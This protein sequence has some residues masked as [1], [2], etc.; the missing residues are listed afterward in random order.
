MQPK[1]FLTDEEMNTL[2]GGTQAPQGTTT[3]EP[4]A[5]PAFIP[6][7]RADEFFTANI[8]TPTP[9]KEQPGKL[10]QIATGIAKGELDLVQGASNVGKT[11]LSPVTKATTG[12]ANII[13]GRKNQSF[14]EGKDILPTQV[15]S[16]LE[17]ETPYESFGKGI[18][19]VVEYSLGGLEKL[20]L[21]AAKA[22]AKGL[23][24]VLLGPTAKKVLSKGA[25][26]LTDF[27]AGFGQSKL[28]GGDN[29]EATISGT[30]VPVGNTVMKGAVKLLGKAA[31]GVTDFV[32][33][34]VATK[35]PEFYDS[36]IVKSVGDAWNSA[37]P[38]SLSTM[39]GAGNKGE[40]ALE[41]LHG[42]ASQVVAN[43]VENKNSLGLVDKLG[44]PR[45]PEN[46]QEMDEAVGTLKKK[47]YQAYTDILKK[48]NP[49]EFIQGVQTDVSNVVNSLNNKL[50]KENSE[51]GR[52]ALTMLIR[53][54]RGLRDTSPIGLQDY[55]ERLRA[56]SGSVFNG[57]S[58]AAVAN[59]SAAVGSQIRD[60]IAKNIENLDGDEYKQLRGLY[61]AFK[62]IESDTE[63]AARNYINNV[64]DKLF[65]SASNIIGG[66]DTL[67]GLVT[68]DPM[69]IMRGL[70][71]KGAQKANAY[72]KS[73]ERNIKKMFSEVENIYNVAKKNTEYGSPSLRINKPKPFDG[74]Q[75]ANSATTNQNTPYS[76]SNPTPPKTIPAA[77]SNTID[78]SVPLNPNGVNGAVPPRQSIRDFLMKKP[79]PEA[80]G[81]QQMKDNILKRAIEEQAALKAKPQYEKYTPPE[82]L[83]VIKTGL[84]KSK[85]FKDTQDKLPVIDA[86]SSKKT[87]KELLQPKKKDPE[88]TVKQVH[89]AVDEFFTMAKGVEVNDNAKTIS[90]AEGVSVSRK[91]LKHI[92]ESRKV[93]GMSGEDIKTLVAKV[94]E[95]L[96]SPDLNIPSPNNEKYQLSTKLYPQENKATIVVHEPDGT[97]ENVVTAYY[98]NQKKYKKY[99]GSLQGSASSGAA[100]ASKDGYPLSSDKSPRMR[101]LDDIQK[102][103][104]IDNS[105][106]ALEGPLTP[107]PRTESSTLQQRGDKLSGVKDSAQTSSKGTL[108]PSDKD[109]KGGGNKAI[110]SAVLGALGLEAVSGQEAEAST[111]KYFPKRINSVV[112]ADI[113]ANAPKATHKEK[114]IVRDMQHNKEKN[115]VVYTVPTKGK[116]DEN[117]QKIIDAL[118]HDAGVKKTVKGTIN[119]ESHGGSNDKNFIRDMGRYGWLVG[120]TAGMVTDAER[121]GVKPDFSTPEK[122]VETL[123]NLV[124]ATKNDM[125]LENDGFYWWEKH[126]NKGATEG[127][128]YALLGKYYNL[129]Q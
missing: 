122:A 66:A 44:Q 118:P 23:S 22:T 29:T 32:K 101:R 111:K 126:H 71:I 9:T 98:K 108:A 36:K 119:I 76:T 28:H 87:V 6:D 40:T 114:N 15:T 57:G 2:G 62:T 58:T 100:S 129:N 99:L 48:S 84:A 37:F 60:I 64:G 25:E 79:V 17:S 104:T 123:A 90:L 80:P 21:G 51:D 105:A 115:D 110:I 43:M 5:P 35:V 65:S 77:I 39:R 31:S 47:V 81:N 102:Q 53:E 68:H 82:K 7:D 128:N 3:M 34:V 94:P 113:K 10:K 45:L 116:I 93:D 52:R 30:A 92:V 121:A 89:D 125:D 19:Q 63:R 33:D 69:A 59:E 95:V 12:L 74:D 86:G 124:Q 4:A 14:L 11:I 16:N 78:S 83:P 120:A 72:L 61:G 91:A 107:H 49:A 97:I 75:A 55:V 1:A 8:P 112:E 50:L 96:K 26:Y 106:L 18:E 13:T 24:K 85:F 27:A 88:E 56:R 109:V 54:L 70:A 46:R 42:S 103:N 127:D 117:L 20:G 41:G 73:P 38:T 67:V